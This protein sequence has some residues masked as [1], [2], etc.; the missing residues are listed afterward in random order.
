MA[1]SGELAQ[2]SAKGAVAAHHH[3][4][5]KIGGV[6][7]EVVDIRAHQGLAAG[8][9][10]H[11]LVRQCRDVVED[12]VH[13]NALSGL[14]RWGGVAGMLILG[15]TLP[16]PAMV[17]HLARAMTNRPVEAAGGRSWWYGESKR[18]IR[19][20]DGGT[21]ILP[22]DHHADPLAEA[23]RW[24]ICEAELIQAI[25]RG[26]GVNR[27]SETPLEVDLLTDVVLPVTID[28]VLSWDE[29]RPGRTDIM[30]ARGVLLDNAADR[31]R[32]FPDLWPTPEA[33][34]Q[35]RWRR[36]TNCYYRNI[37][38]SEMLRSSIT[39]TYQP[40]GAGQKPRRAMFDLDVIEDPRAWLE[41]R[42]GTLIL[43][44]VER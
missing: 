8:Q 36:V 19:L 38:N 6:A 15:R 24:S 23:I 3:H 28:T 31:A 17:E 44:D 1:R 39:V 21:Q 2:I 16:S 34:K 20:A 37:S 10:H 27:T 40:A 9:D 7:G 41:Q 42:L 11:G 25:G 13:F 14:D 12:A 5:A 30:A 4:Q 33:A 22:G 43:L 26:R 32:C 35:D 29:A 18:A